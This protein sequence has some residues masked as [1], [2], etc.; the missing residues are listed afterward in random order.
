MFTQSAEK[1][2][3]A[4]FRLLGFEI[5]I[6]QRS[7][8]FEIG[9]FPTEGSELSPLQ[10]LLPAIIEKD[11]DF[12]FV[13]V[14]ANDGIRSDLIR[15]FILKY[16]LRGICVEP[17]CDMFEKLK[18]NYSTEPQLIFENVAVAKEDGQM[19]LYRF[20]PDTPGPDYIQGM[21]SFDKWKLRRV[22]LRH[23]LTSWI[24]EVRV[25]S[26]TFSHLI[27]RNNVN[28]ISLLQ[29]DTE[30]FD[31]EVVK[32]ALDSGVLPSLINYEVI[33]LTLKDRRESYRL[34]TSKGYSLIHG[35]SDTLAVHEGIL[36][37]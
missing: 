24:E 9:L 21:P 30:G 6:I 36:E 5:K 27:R 26:V 18:A 2:L 16:H 25:P 17:L 35:R 3:L 31:F 1:A 37:V 8:G 22:A 11:K 14:G 29:I 33:N 4:V 13:Q 34:L 10:L 28:K 20:K 12:F 23:G 19:T 7:K 32:M 15:S